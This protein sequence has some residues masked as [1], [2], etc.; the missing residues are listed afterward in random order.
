MAVRKAAPEPALRFQAGRDVGAWQEALRVRLAAILAIAPSSAAPLVPYVTPEAET[1]R[2]TMERIR[3][4]AEPG[5]VV[6]GYLLRPKQARGPLPVMICLQGHSPGMHISI[7][8]ARNER[9]KA[10][11][12]GGRDLALQAVDRG[13]AALVIEQRG[14][15]ERAVGAVSCNDTALRALHAGRPLTGQRVL[16]VQRAVDFIGTQPGLDAARIACIGNSTGG[17]V[18]FYAAC[19]EPRIGL[20]VVSCSFCTFEDSWMSLPHCACGYLPGILQ[21]AD[22]PDLA[23]LIA[24][25]RLLIVAGKQDNLARFAGVE[26]GFQR[27]Q[28][29]FAAAGVGGNVRL[30]AGEGG[31]QFYP[32]QAWP[33]IAELAAGM[34]D[35][36]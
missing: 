2:Y 5:E 32:D 36:R 9:E 30:I 26:R 14:F 10:S 28:E 31:H 7:G 17:T 13:W 21:V 3:F 19:V 33:V 4:T 15:G 6:P 27:A 20:A 24:P 23:G 22:M 8:Q 12:A 34:T 11:I 18:S 25:R 1:A 29:I 16:D 35:R